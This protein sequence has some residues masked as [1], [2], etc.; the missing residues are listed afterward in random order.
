M[1][2]I[3]QLWIYPVKA[4]Q[5]IRLKSAALSECGF[6]YDR[7]WCVVD[8]SGERY[9]AREQ[10]S[11]RKLPFL[12]SLAVRFSDDQ[13]QLIISAPE[14]PDLAV[15]VAEEAYASN[16][17]ILVECGGLSTT[18]SGGWQLGRMRGRSAGKAASD[19]LSLYLNRV[20]C[21]RTKPEARYELVRSVK[22]EIRH[23]ARYA[24]PKQVPYNECLT[25]QAE[26][27]GS[28]FRMQSVDVVAGDAV[29]FCDFSPF[30]LV[31]EDSHADLVAR[32]GTGSYP[33]APFRA[34]IVV[35]GTAAP[36]VEETWRDFAIGET[37]F[38]F[39]KR[40]PRCTVPSRDQATGGLNR[41]VAGRPMLAQ[42]TLRTAF[43]AKC[44][45]DEWGREWEGP[46]YGIHVAHGGVAGTLCEGDA[47]RVSR[48]GYDSW[49][50]RLAASPKALLLLAPAVPLLALAAAGIVAARRGRPCG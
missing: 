18:S 44:T 28:P 29:R 26:S 46:M 13:H 33:I 45:D 23:M 47:V 15:P 39:L 35:A 38:R 42:A 37:P 6:E 20:D 31:S 50:E 7:A 48:Y 40:V 19:W 24:G 16:E 2:T 3:T 17:E 41:E 49:R 22:P 32:M 21:T 27:R 34:N 25:A 11:Q 43:P 4:C 12:A 36:W 9:R 30:H 5:G 8:S 10:L 14:M 1:A